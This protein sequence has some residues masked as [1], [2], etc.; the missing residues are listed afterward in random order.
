MARYERVRSLA[1][2]WLGEEPVEFA[3]QSLGGGTAP[4]L[5]SWIQPWLSSIPGLTADWAQAIAGA[6]IARAGTS[7]NDYLR[8]YGTGVLKE[9]AMR[10]I[11]AYVHPG[12]SIVVER[13]GTAQA[14]PPIVMSKEDQLQ[15]YCEQLARTPLPGFTR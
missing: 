2:D 8:A 14:P 10:L 15:A 9:L 12:G 13:P 11:K 4:I 7:Y 6:V 3:V 5:M 1:T